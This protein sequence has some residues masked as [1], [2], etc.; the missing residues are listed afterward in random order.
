MAIILDGK[1]LAKATRRELKA[2]VATLRAAGITPAL[3]VILVGDD[4]ASRVY[5][6]NKERACERVGIRSTID[7]LPASTPEDAL[8][9]RMEEVNRDPSVHGLLVQLP[10]P[11][12]VNEAR[13]TAAVARDK[14]VDGFHLENV[15]RLV[16][17]AP[18]FVPCTPQ[19]VMRLLDA[20]EVPLEGRRAV[21]VGRSD[22]VGKPVASLLLARHAT[23]TLC[24]S[25]TRDLADEVARADVLVAAVGR[26]RMIQGAW[27]KPGSAVLDVGINRLQDGSLCGDVD[28]AAAEARAGWITPVPGGVG[29]MT[30]T[31]LLA[32]TVLAAESVCP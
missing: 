2:R 28:F 13:V 20:H 1:A 18:G 7:R 32:N 15:G 10:L 30:I 4:P 27:I 6:R 26:P 3:H 25:R 9:A 14:D 12:G 24:H 21:V 23:V 5:V 17:G 19:A 8:L 16:T 29:P 11:D 22:I 31:V